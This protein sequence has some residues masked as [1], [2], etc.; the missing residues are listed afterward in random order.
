MTSDEIKA[1]AGG[2]SFQEPLAYTVER[3]CQMLL[4]IST[5]TFRRYLTFEA[6]GLTLHG[7]KTP[8]IERLRKHEAWAPL[9]VL[10]KQLDADNG[11]P[12]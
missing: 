9:A 6:R 7:P 4:G 2:T 11:G 1:I 12:K 8:K 3:G 5:K 10:I